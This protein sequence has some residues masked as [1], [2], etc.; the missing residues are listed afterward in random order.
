MPVERFGEELVEPSA[1]GLRVGRM[2][3]Q[4]LVRFCV[5]RLD[6]DGL[7]FN[8]SVRVMTLQGDAAAWALRVVSRVFGSRPAV[9]F[10]FDGRSL[11]ND[12]QSEELAG[13]E[14]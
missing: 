13:F 3:A 9:D 4:G 8:H 1:E 14:A 7:E 12:L 11:G 5:E 2:R 6:L 10:D